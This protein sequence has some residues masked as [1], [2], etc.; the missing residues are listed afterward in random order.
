MKKLVK[1]KIAKVKIPAV[2]TSMILAMSGMKGIDFKRRRKTNINSKLEVKPKIAPKSAKA[3]KRSIIPK[4][5][6]IRCKV[7]RGF[8][9]VLDEG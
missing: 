9:R 5:L 4:S 6:S 3:A 8:L 1:P 7:L 2:M